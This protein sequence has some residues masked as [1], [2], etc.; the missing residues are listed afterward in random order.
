MLK[1]FPHR[2]TEQPRRIEHG[3]R[4]AKRHRRRAISIFRRAGAFHHARQHGLRNRQIARAH[5]R[6]H[7]LTRLLHNR[8][9][10]EGGDVV[11][12]CIGPGIG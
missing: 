3:R 10:G 1:D 7:A 9:L 11:D 2:F 12:A 5:H 4:V 8:E 6:D